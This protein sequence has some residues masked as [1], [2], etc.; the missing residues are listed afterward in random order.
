MKR[1]IS[2][3]E[4]KMVKFFKKRLDSS[5]LHRRKGEV[6]LELLILLIMKLYHSLFQSFIFDEIS[7]LTI[8]FAYFCPFSVLFNFKF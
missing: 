3:I 1:V 8:T 5:I 6:R 4:I 2:N 7:F